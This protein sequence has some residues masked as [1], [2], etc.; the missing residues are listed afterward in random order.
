MTEQPVVLFGDRAILVETDDVAGAHA[1]AALLA[2]RLARG[3]APVGIDEVVVGFANV[4]VV[5]DADEPD[6][7][8]VA[9]WVTQVAASAGARPTRD[10]RQVRTHV[11]PVVFDGPDLAEV[12]ATVGHPLDRVVDGVVSADLE[13]AFVGFAPGFPY[14]T[15]LPPELA[16]VPRRATPRTS[17]PAGSVAIAA[18]FA[19][20][21]PRSTPGGWHLLGRTP[22]SL[23]DP[24]VTPHSLVAPGDRVRF[25]VVGDAD[26]ADV[27]IATVRPLLGADGPCIEVREPGLATTVQDGGRRGCAHDGVSAAGAADTVALALANLLV[28][29]QSDAAAL[30][31]TASGPTLRVVGEGYLAVVGAGPGAVEV[32][33]DG[34]PAPDGAVLAVNDGQVVRIGR[35]GLGL[36]AYVAVS[37]GLAT[38]VLFGSRSSDALA[39]LGPGPLRVGDR[40]ARGQPARPRGHLDPATPSS[41]NHRVL[42]VMAGPHGSPGDGLAGRTW[43]VGVEVDRIGVRLDPGDGPRLDAGGPRASTPMVTGAIQVP[44]DGRPI[45]LLC[46]HA[47]VGGYPVV[48]CVVTADLP[49]LGQLRPG[50]EVAFRE[51]DLATARRLAVQARRSTAS[52]VGGWFPTAAGT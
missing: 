41:G 33:V 17:V 48:A 25:T 3:E 47:T 52:R 46:D 15:G 40:L 29:N 21:Y 5:L 42:S 13:V 19:S 36:R 34:H 32:S 28:G 14:V 39:G 49:V 6:V 43:R 38:P 37:G 11:L 50:D 30:E 31:C 24:D 10:D 27:S 26:F 44:P 45:V 4:L 7:D 23:F 2:S 1:L 51:V 18:G 8:V 16:A 9:G 35:I 20:V 12:A 22:T